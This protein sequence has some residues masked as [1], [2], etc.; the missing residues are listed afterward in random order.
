MRLRSRGEGYTHSVPSG[1][2]LGLDGLDVADPVAVPSPE[3]ARVVD[4][5]GVD[6][7]HRVDVS[8]CLE[9]GV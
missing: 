4:A 2:V 1:T 9:D 3:G 6:T 8:V 7:N 5:D